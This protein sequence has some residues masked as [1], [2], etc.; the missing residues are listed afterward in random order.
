MAQENSPKH[1]AKQA[2]QVI[3]RVSAEKRAELDQVAAQVEAELGSRVKKA[4]PSQ[5]AM[6]KFN[7]TLLREGLSYNDLIERPGMDRG[8]LSKLE[9]NVD[10]IELNTLARLA[11]VLGYDIVVEF[12]KRP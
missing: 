7:L 8:D 2:S 3:G 6:A 10:N 12:C 4:S 1:L 9:D 11:D 5:I